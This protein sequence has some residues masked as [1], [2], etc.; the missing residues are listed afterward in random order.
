[1]HEGKK[2]ES[3]IKMDPYEETTRTLQESAFDE[4]RRWTET[5]FVL[6]LCTCVCSAMVASVALAAVLSRDP[7]SPCTLTGLHHGP[8]EDAYNGFHYAYLMNISTLTA[9][10]FPLLYIFVIIFCAMNYRCTGTL[11]I[12][13]RKVVYVLIPFYIAS[14]VFNSFA[15]HLLRRGRSEC[16]TMIRACVAHIGIGCAMLTECIM[17][18]LLNG[19][20]TVSLDLGELAPDPEDANVA[21][22]EDEEDFAYLERRSGPG[23]NLYRTRSH[24][25]IQDT[26]GAT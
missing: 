11:T 16:R 10:L 12:N 1:M 24:N 3:R 22:P 26:E 25:R 17:F 19:K 2:G 21:S 4:L 6:I 7:A 14:I 5:G 23:R 13:A 9:F 8:S 20:S 18:C 15:F